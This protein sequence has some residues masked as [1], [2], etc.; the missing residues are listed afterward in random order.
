MTT[1]TTSAAQARARAL[2]FHAPALLLFTVL[3]FLLAFPL[4]AGLFDGRIPGWEGDNLYYV[5]SMW[6]VKRALFELHILPFVDVTAYYPVGH[7]IARSEMTPTNTLLFLPVTLMAG[8]EM[9]YNVA[10][11]FSFIATGFGTYLW[12]HHLTGSRASG[13]LAGTIVAFL[14]YRFSHL[15]GHLPQMTTQWIPLTLYAFERFLDERTIRRAVWLGV[16]VALTCVGCWYY[17]YALALVFPVYALV[18][19]WENPAVWRD[20]AWWIGIGVSALVAVALMGPF[21]YQMMKLTSQGALRRSIGELYTWG[22]NFYDMFIPNLIHPFWGETASRWFPKQRALWPEKVHTLGFAAMA[23]A[24][25]GIIRWRR[26]RRA[27]VV[28]LCAVWLVSYSIAL[29]P[30]LS[31]GDELVR[32]RLPRAL[33]TVAAAAIGEGPGTPI[34]HSFITEGVPVPL[35]SAF[36]YKFVPLT[37]SMRVM[38]RFSF[39]TA[40]ATAALAGFGLLTLMAAAERR[41]GPAARGA[42]AA[43]LIALVAFESLSVVPMMAV[44]P[45]Q[46]DL[47]LQQQ[48]DDVIF[49]ELPVEQATRGFQNYWAIHS[50]RRNLFGW[51][52][53]S[54]SPPVQIERMAALKDFPAPSS[55]DFLQR[56]GATYVLLTPSQIPTWGTME[57]RVNAE[58]ALQ[59]VQTFNDVRVYRV[60]RQPQT[61]SKP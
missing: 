58:P 7:Q 15:P 45:R 18:R 16:G 54:F 32:L 13:L 24:L 36:L 61:V 11:V 56:S 48:P 4:V 37:S 47:W 42:L 14:P 21:L 1:S 31:A 33:A 35:P 6:W 20:R 34:R 43:G 25:V 2:A 3:T 23:V 59:P 38:A 8:P 22:L 19:T 10:L 57:P 52:G 17:G 53:D 41:W 49:V 55:I 27:V 51:S 44:G 40:L 29:G 5:R 9:A 50:Q 30:F 28:A 46:V 60:V 39:W 26:R 12:V